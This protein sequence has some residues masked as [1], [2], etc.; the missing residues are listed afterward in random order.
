MNAI[1]LEATIQQDG[2]L[3]LTDLPFRKGDRIE[4]IIF[5]PGVRQHCNK[6]ELQQQEARQRFLD[7]ACASTFRSV[8]PYPSRD[9]LHERH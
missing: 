6:K 9:E 8:E 4:A 7:L 5:V 3:H 2:E 1:K